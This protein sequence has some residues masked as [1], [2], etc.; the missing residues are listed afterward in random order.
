MNYRRGGRVVSG[1]HVVVVLDLDDCLA[2]IDPNPV[3][4]LRTSDLGSFDVDDAAIDWIRAIF[5]IEADVILRSRVVVLD[6]RTH[7]DDVPTTD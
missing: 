6:V 2:G 7:D 4:E 1:K 3:S 5:D